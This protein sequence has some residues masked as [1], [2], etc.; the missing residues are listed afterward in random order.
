MLAVNCLTPIVYISCAGILA[1]GLVSGADYVPTNV[2]PKNPKSMGV[3]DCSQLPPIR[4]SISN[5]HSVLKIHGASRVKFNSKT[6]PVASDGMWKPSR[7]R[8]PI[9][10][11]S[12]NVA[13]FALLTL[14]FTVQKLRNAVETEQY[15]KCQRLRNPGAEEMVGELVLVALTLRVLNDVL[16]SFFIDRQ[17]CMKKCLL[18]AVRSV[19][20]VSSASNGIQVFLCNAAYT[21]TITN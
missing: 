11:L 15:Q 10:K 4:T 5:N 6:K 12:A 1:S 14:P 2:H 8:I 9:Y 13:N 20:A 17:V 16:I 7:F 21:E 18:K 3:G 19:K